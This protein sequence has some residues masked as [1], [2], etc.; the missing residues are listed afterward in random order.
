MCI[1]DSLH[2]GDQVA[3]ANCLGSLSEFTHEEAGKYP[4]SFLILAA[5]EHAQVLAADYG[6][7]TAVP[8][9]QK[10][11]LHLRNVLFLIVGIEPGALIGKEIFA[12]EHRCV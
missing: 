10:T 1:R 9:R 11:G 3:A 12:A 7:G 5:V 4:C 6:S 8:C 2:S